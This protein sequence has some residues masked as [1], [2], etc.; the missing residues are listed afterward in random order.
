MIIDLA[1]HL[2]LDTDQLHIQSAL[3]NEDLVEEISMVPP[4]GIGRDAKILRLAKTLYSLKQAL[5]A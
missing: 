3:G 5:L 2:G 4:P 1:T